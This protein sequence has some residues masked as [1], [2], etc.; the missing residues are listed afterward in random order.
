M[1][2]SLVLDKPLKF[3]ASYMKKKREEGP[4]DKKVPVLS[5]NKHENVGIFW[6]KKKNPTQNSEQQWLKGEQ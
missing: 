1:Y 3:P 2:R 6:K 4:A 5:Q